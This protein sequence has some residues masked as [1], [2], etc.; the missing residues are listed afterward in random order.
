MH[1]EDV[2]FAIGFIALLGIIIFGVVCMVN[3]ADDE[4]WTF[5]NDDCVHY[6]KNIN[7]WGADKHISETYC[8]ATLVPRE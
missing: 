6:S 8:I 5:I 7:T 4:T 3:L 1:D 2:A